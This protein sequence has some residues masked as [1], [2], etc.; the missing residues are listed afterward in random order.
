MRDRL[1]D[2][3]YLPRAYFSGAAPENNYTPSEPWTLVIYKDPV[4]APEEY[5]YLMAET[6]GADSRRR[7]QFRI[8]D[9]IHYLWEYP[10]ILSGIRLPAEEDPWS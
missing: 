5:A 4:A 3:L 8:K 6:A 7:I 9:G 2:K 10:G 1:G